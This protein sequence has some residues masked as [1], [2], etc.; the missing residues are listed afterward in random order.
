MSHFYS[1]LLKC[2]CGKVF[3]N[4][5][6]SLSKNTI[7]MLYKI[8][9]PLNFLLFTY[10]AIALKC[11]DI[12]AHMRGISQIFLHISSKYAILSLDKVREL[13]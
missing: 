6:T 2:T 11:K 9:R 3:K 1:I 13:R 5:P 8:E 7:G 4:F 12:Y 10:L